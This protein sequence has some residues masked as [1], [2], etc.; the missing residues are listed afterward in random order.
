MTAYELIDI[1]K[2]VPEDCEILIYNPTFSKSYVIYD[3][4]PLS[5]IEHDTDGTPVAWLQTQQ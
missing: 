3:M 4:E 5:E 2:Q 1:L